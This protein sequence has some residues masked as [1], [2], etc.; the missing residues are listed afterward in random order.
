M[1]L[2][3]ERIAVLE[4]NY[5]TSAVAELVIPIIGIAAFKARVEVCISSSLTKDYSSL[6]ISF[7][8]ECNC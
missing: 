3:Y 4:I 1:R 6:K 2:L 7:A 5:Y 8:F